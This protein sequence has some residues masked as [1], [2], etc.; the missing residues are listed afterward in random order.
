MSSAPKRKLSLEEYFVIER[1]AQFKSEYFDG[2]MFAI[3]GASAAH[4]C[5]KDNLIMEL[6]NRL[7]GTNCRTLSSDQRLKVERT[8]LVTYPDVMIICGKVELSADDQDT[9]TNPVAIVEILSP[10]TERYDRTTKF[11][12]YQ[13][14]N[15]L[16]EY[17]LIAQDEPL[18]ERYV[19]QDDGSWAL[20]SF[21]GLT[22][23]LIFTS[24]VADIPLAD[25]YSG[26]SFPEDLPDN[27][28]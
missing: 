4:N 7:K 1:T 6:G 15:T 19:R 16:N 13:T 18:C 5:I 21:V 3:A 8:G 23:K 27:I 22:A 20:V 17:I 28:K 2:E 24:V 10:R 14:L 25:L 26:I 9:I 11:R 12:N